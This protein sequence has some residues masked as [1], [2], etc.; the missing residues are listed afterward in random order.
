MT[1]LVNIKGEAIEEAVPAVTPLSVLKELVADMESGKL[2]GVERLLVIGER[3]NPNDLSMVQSF[4]R[5]SGLTIAQTVF[6]MEA[7]RFRIF[8]MS[9]PC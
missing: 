8:K 3:T 9:H 6:M 4:T 2:V 7:E 1:N 5:E